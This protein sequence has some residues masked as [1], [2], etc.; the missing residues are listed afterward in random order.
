M[1]GKCEKCYCKKTV[2]FKRCTKQVTQDKKKCR[3]L[4]KIPIKQNLTRG[5]TLYPI[6]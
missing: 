6:G 1:V 5:D 4:W 3:K 2:N